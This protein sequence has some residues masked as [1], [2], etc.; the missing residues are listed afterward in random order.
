VALIALVAIC[1]GTYVLS[2]F[3]FGRSVIAG[4]FELLPR[5]KGAAA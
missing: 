5:R 1:A 3:I 2:L 4:F